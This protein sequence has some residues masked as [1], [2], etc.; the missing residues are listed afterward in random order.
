MAVAVAAR[1]A[2]PLVLFFLVSASLLAAD[3]S[4]EVLENYA[5]SLF[6]RCRRVF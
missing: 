2:T 3:A 6:R 5:I 1:R 4:G